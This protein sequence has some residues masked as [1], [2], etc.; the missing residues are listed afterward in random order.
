M[1]KSFD[2]GRARRIIGPDLG[3][4]YC[5]S[6]Q[7]TTLEDP[8]SLNAG[9]IFAECSKRAFCNTFDLHKATICL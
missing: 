7:Q 6:Y 1:S 3:P 4:K 2:P 8:L 9:Q 5:K